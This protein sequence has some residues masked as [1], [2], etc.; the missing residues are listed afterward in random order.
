MIALNGA[1]LKTAVILVLLGQPISGDHHKVHTLLSD[2][3]THRV[4]QF[5]NGTMYHESNISLFATEN[6]YLNQWRCLCALTNAVGKP[7]RKVSWLGRSAGHW[8][9]VW[10]WIFFVWFDSMSLWLTDARIERTGKG[11]FGKVE[12]D[13]WSYKMIF[14]NCCQLKCIS[15]LILN[16][17]VVCSI[18]I[19]WKIF[20][21]TSI[22]WAVITAQDSCPGQRATLRMCA[23][24]TLTYPPTDSHPVRCS[25]EP[26][27]LGSVHVDSYAE[28]P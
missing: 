27:F 23:L 22:A 28:G 24:S 7:R 17:S 14:E 4:G 3:G 21:K 6:L 8:K 25:A 26:K 1:L 9:T 16:Y 15:I 5:V 11:L 18:C 20:Q 19:S 2:W 13:V 10:D 12:F